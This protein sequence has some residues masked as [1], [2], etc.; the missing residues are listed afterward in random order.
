MNV[1]RRTPKPVDTIAEGIKEAF[2]PFI[3]MYRDSFRDEENKKREFLR[4][5]PALAGL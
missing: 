1:E 4:N 3:E 2:K 5:R